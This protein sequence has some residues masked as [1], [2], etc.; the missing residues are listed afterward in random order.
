MMAACMLSAGS[1]WADIN[2][3]PFVVPELKT[4]TGAEGQTALS[5]R[6]VVN[7][8]KLKVVAES[9]ANDYKEMFGKSL[10]IVSGTA[11]GGDIVLSLKKNK[12]LGD[13]GYSM[14]IGSAVELSAAT[15]H[16]LFW[17][18]R[19]LLQVSEQHKDGKLPKGKT[20]DVPEYKLRGFMI[21]CGR[22]YIPMSY[23]RNLTKIMAYYKM[24]TLQ[25]HLNDNGFRQ[26]FGNDWSKT[27]AAFRL[28]C[29]TYPGLTAKDGSYTKQEFID[30]QKL[31][32]Q[33]GVEIIPEIDAP[34]HSLAFTQYK[35]ELGSKEYGMDHLDLFNPETYKFMDGLWK[36]Y[37]G[38]KNPVFR[39][40]RVHIGT[41]EYSNAK[42]DV[43]EKF[44]EYTDH[45]IK[46]VESY[47]KQAVLWGALTHANG[48]TPV[49][50]KNV[51]MDIWYNGYAD[52]VEMKKQGYKLVSIPDGLTYIVPAAGYYYDYLNCQYL[53][54][55]YTPAVIGNKT[56]EENDPDILG[57][58]FAVWND[59]AG[60]GI[61]TK[62][63]HHRVYPALQTLA[64]KCWTGK[65]TKLPYA[66]FDANRKNL[67]E[68]P[69]VN[70]LG[71]LGK[72]GTV[73]LT[74]DVVKP[75]EQL[76]A[77][78]IGY[79]YAVTFTVDGKQENKG[80]ELFRSANAVVYLSD[81]EQ[82]KLGF[83]RDGYRNLF[84]YRIPVGEKHTIT[85]EGTNKVTRLL[86]DGNLK[87][88]LG[89]K[90]LYVMRDQDRAH[91]QVKGTYSYE[92]VV[93][94][95]TDQIY[96]QRTLV[97]PLRHAGQFKSAITNLKVEVK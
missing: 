23:L 74:K 16:G 46:L 72:S 41:D 30:L 26:Y 85:I 7:N 21:D 10:S 96:Y 11:K 59:H 2:P 40:P 56:F 86:V 52:P 4:W 62:D 9:L 20:V 82:G 22:K 31:A 76:D 14:N 70:E 83:E 18:T 48:T 29:D 95:P 13:E 63:V 71:R 68:A 3:K 90:T 47:G 77:E 80:T 75:G 51:I 19:T 37:V 57:G 1:L 65:N 6:I 24:N 55:H 91:Y 34:A 89:P 93:Y 35:N 53:Y 94:Q 61:S 73:A 39:G 49:K 58:M 36:E 5:G 92:P 25:V 60:N 78:E 69:G 44:R 66:E 81:P 88:E 42:K 28:E 32:E 38:G 8:A 84:N 27:Q 67:S 87:E 17:A 15:E 79:N 12:A 33:N 64:V 45:Y 97:F 43:V 50:N 54:E